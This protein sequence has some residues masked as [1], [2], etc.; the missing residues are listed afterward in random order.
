MASVKWIMMSAKSFYF[1]YLDI[2]FYNS[3]NK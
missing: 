1:C 3:R 2:I